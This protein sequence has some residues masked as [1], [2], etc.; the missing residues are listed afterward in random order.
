MATVRIGRL[1]IARVLEDD[2]PVFDPGA[3]YPDSTAED[4]EASGTG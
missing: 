1:E 4:F 2:T 3:M